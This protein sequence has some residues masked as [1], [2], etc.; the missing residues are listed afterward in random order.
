MVT[1]ESRQLSCA[2]LLE[3]KVK[4]Q[5]TLQ[6]CS[7]FQCLRGTRA[8]TVQESRAL[9]CKCNLPGG[10]LY[11]HQTGIIVGE[12]GGIHALLCHALL[13]YCAGSA[14]QSGSRSLF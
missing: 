4:R 2:K 11:F 13:K 8:I 7:A 14:T 6:S 3:A 10:H 1:D 12:E 5:M 9:T